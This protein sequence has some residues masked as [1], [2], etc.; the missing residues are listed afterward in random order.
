MGAGR[1]RALDIDE[2]MPVIVRLFWREGF[3]RLTLDEIASELGVTKPTLYRSFGDKEELLAKALESYIQ[4]YIF[5]GQELLRTTPTLREALR[6]CFRSSIDRILDELNPDGCFF[7][8]TA[9]SGEFSEGPVAVVVQ[10]HLGRTVRILA[11]R[12]EEAIASGELADGTDPESVQRYVIAQFAA[13]S[14]IS[15]LTQGREELE[16]MVDFMVAGL[17]WAGSAADS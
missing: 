2:A 8:D 15:R 1:P 3:G 6:L 14:A 13:I 4:R 12:I 10:K 17:P 9:F 11:E 7:S 16:R 5:P